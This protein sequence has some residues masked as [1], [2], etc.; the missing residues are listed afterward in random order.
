MRTKK[1]NQ[2]KTMKLEPA[3]FLAALLASALML[4]TARSAEIHDAARADD[5]ARIS[6]MLATNQAL[7]AL[8]GKDGMTPLHLA[9]REGMMN[10][11][12][13]LLDHG[14]DVNAADTHGCT[15]LHS[16]VYA[17]NVPVAEVLLDRHANPNM[18]RKDGS[19][20]LF[21]AAGNG[22]TNLVS[23]L[24]KRG[25]KPA[26]RPDAEFSP[27]H[28]ATRNGHT[29][30]IELLVAAGASLETRD[31]EGQTPLH[32]AARMGDRNLA[33]WLVNHGADADAKDRVRF[34]PR[35]YVFGDTN[36]ALAMLLEQH[37]KTRSDQK[38]P[39][40]V[41]EAGDPDHIAFAGLQSFTA[42]QIRH[43]LLEKPSYMIASHPQANM[44]VFFEALR[45]MVESGYQAQGFPDSKVEVRYDPDGLQLHVN[46][47]EG[48]HFV[49]RKIRVVGAK[50]S[51]T[52]Q[53]VNW[54]TTPAGQPT[55][56]ETLHTSSVSKSSQDSNGD[57][58]TVAASVGLTVAK[59]SVLG[60]PGK[61]ERPDEPM[62]VRGDP[63]DFSAAWST[64]A[65]AQVESCLAEQ[66]FFF[67]KAKVKLQRDNATGAADLVIT[68]LSE[69]PPGVIGAIK[70]T[71]ADRD[72]PADI[73]RFLDL[74][75]GG[76]ITA[77]RLVAARKKLWDCG[78]FWSFAITP[79]FGD[80]NAV[81]SRRV[82]LLIEVGEQEGV[83]R[84]NAPLSP[85]Q[86]AL[87]RL[88][89]WLEEFPERDEDIQVR[90]TVPTVPPVAVNFVL[91]PKRGLLL[92]S[93]D[94]EGRSPVSLGF[95]LT[96]ELI[97]MCSWASG[98]KLAAAR[99]GG[100]SFFLHLLPERSSES[101]HFNLSL[102]A[103]YKNASTPKPMLAFDVQL[104]PAA[105]L[106][107]LTREDSGCRLEG[108]SL[109][110]SNMGVT[111]RAEAATGRVLAID[112]GT[113]E[114]A[115]DIRFDAKVW[116]R[117]SRDF[118]HRSAGLTNLYVPDHGLSSFLG[119]AF[120]ELARWKLT[121]TMK[122]DVSEAQRARALAA[123]GK[124]VNPEYLFPVDRI[125][126]EDGTN[127]F[128]L[129]MDFIDRAIQQNPLAAFSG[130][131]FQ[132]N[133]A[134]FPK[135]SWP[136]TVTRETVFNF[137]G[138]NQFTDVELQRLYTD[139]ETGPIGCLAVASLFGK[140]GSPLAK[141]FAMEGLLRMGP[142]DFLR[143]C[144]L[145]LR[146]ESGLARSVG[147]TLEALRN[148]P[149]DE[150]AALAAVLPEA[151][152]NLLRESAAGLRATP[153]GAPANVLAP[154]LGKYWEESLRVKVRRAL[155][156]LTVPSEGVGTAGI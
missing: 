45:E 122:S 98:G 137:M 63:A 4:G 130:Y 93:Y 103:G 57:D 51:S 50:S 94:A 95:L 20:P 70:V 131:I 155:Q 21:Y 82:D 14:A 11:V 26:G 32:A 30:V 73:L 35:D 9:A 109:V 97:Q 151:E 28:V 140:P 124:L 77:R 42:A 2:L 123:V 29:A 114:Q 107:L 12:V 85:E 149:E 22:D 101:N 33:E 110:V 117:A 17:R 121:T 74:R 5:V 54:F 47:A 142:R 84:L 153:N 55:S 127:N 83:P 128:H 126:G 60:T 53:I 154:A 138:L 106:D 37:M 52:K 152:A 19:T 120:T 31:K 81:T 132:L 18:S 139:E 25:G 64:Q 46:V 111:L 102:G 78:R 156:K 86:Q 147:K 76:K 38:L 23:L 141:T 145:L 112:R 113:N 40:K 61:A 36:L 134:Y 115:I 16:A 66:G 92:D 135:Y 48:P 143:D 65:V 39:A 146:G 96:P 119:C 1:I 89:K 125:L 15:P 69:G 90:V 44:R 133:A 99:N 49:A 79:E 13:V 27:L 3:K 87:V 41:G 108:G 136:W 100:G 105:F 118:T 24:L 148:L 67:P 8:P 34:T 80:G 7:I 43:G 68:L 58:T 56:V 6:A 88:C 91:S 144:N 104:A 116:D 10:A 72:T 71:G 129:P 75:K 59:H 62:W 150:V